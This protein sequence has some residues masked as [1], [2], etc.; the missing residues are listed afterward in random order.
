MSDSDVFI[1]SVVHHAHPSEAIRQA[2]DKAEVDASRVRDVIFGLDESH[3]IDADEIL[4]ASALTCSRAVVKSSLRA[5]FFAAQS[6]LSGDADVVV[7]LGMGEAG[8]TGILLASPDAVGRWNLMPCARLAV[9]SLTGMESAL[10]AAGIELK[11]VSIIQDGKNG[12]ALIRDVL[13]ALE[14]QSARWGLVTEGELALLIER[15]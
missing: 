15:I 8:S 5:V 13:E 10:R 12:A 6:V 14:Q 3:S 11:D 7:V 9:R 1:I 4:N 2:I